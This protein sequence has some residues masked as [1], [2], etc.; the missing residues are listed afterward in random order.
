MSKR[1]VVGLDGSSYARGALELAVRRAHHYRSTLIGVSVVDRPAIEQ[2]EIGAYPAA[3]HVSHETI[4]RLLNE[5]KERAQRRIAEFRAVCEAEGIPHEDIIHSGD[6]AS[7][8]IE[9]GKTADMIIVGIRTFFSTDPESDPDTTLRD[10]FKDPVCPVLAVPERLDL[11]RNVIFT[12]D[13]TAGA[14]RALHAYVHV[15]PQPPEEI[16]MNLLCVSS[17]YEKNKF[18]LEK[19]ESYLIAHGLH[20]RVLVRSGSPAEVIIE[21]AKE[22]MPSLVILGT[23]YYRGLTERIFGSVTATIIGDG[24][25]PVFVY[26]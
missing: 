2:V 11:P 6:A 18:Y 15:T 12:Y 17:E 8:L 14:A 22:M 7:A 9:E 5:A 3:L 24:T 16:T 19:A 1:I 25:I 23:P 13:G 10:L 26:H 21:T 20:P 4:S